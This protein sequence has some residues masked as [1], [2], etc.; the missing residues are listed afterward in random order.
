MAKHFY[1]LVGLVLGCSSAEP[2]APPS[3]M[4]GVAGQSGDLAGTGGDERGESGAG[5]GG[6]GALPTAGG[7]SRATGGDATTAK[8]HCLIRQVCGQIEV[9]QGDEHRESAVSQASNKPCE[10]DLVAGVQV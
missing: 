2:A 10:R 3:A 8:Q 1:G 6:D 4:G 7:G 5:I 9:V